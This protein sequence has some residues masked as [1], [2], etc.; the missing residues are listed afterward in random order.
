MLNICLVVSVPMTVNKFLW[1]YIN[2]LADH[3]KVTLVTGGSRA[4]LDTRISPI[5]LKSRHFGP[6]MGSVRGFIQGIK[7]K[8]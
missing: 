1:V 5:S 4:D 8:V 2:A 7:Q 3:Y 6:L